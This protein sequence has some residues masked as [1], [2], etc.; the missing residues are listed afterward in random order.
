[1]SDLLK[2]ISKSYL[3]KISIDNNGVPLAL[4]KNSPVCIDCFPE[5]LNS[6]LKQYLDI[7]EVVEN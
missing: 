1:M 3:T 2:E 7:K 6:V 4:K 5:V